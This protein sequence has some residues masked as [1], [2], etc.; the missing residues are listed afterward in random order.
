MKYIQGNDRAINC[1]KHKVICGITHRS[2]KSLCEAQCG[3]PAA[4]LAAPNSPPGSKNR[5]RGGPQ[6]SW[7][8]S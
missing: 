1:I 7:T 5:Q 2:L 3:S 4:I 8:V 6:M